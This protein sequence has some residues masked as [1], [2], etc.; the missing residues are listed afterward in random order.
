MR[1]AEGLGGDGGG[2]EVQQNF[3]PLHPKLPA[4][5]VIYRHS[6]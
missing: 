5:D 2:P 6:L 4:S 3:N 1:G